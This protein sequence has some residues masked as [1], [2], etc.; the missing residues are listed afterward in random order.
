MNLHLTY[1]DYITHRHPFEN[2]YQGKVVTTLIESR[3]NIYPQAT[4]IVYV[5]GFSDYF[6]QT[7]VM[8]YL[9]GCGVNFYAIDLRKCGRSFMSHQSPNYCQSLREYFAD[10]D[11]AIEFILKKDPYTKIS[12]LGHSTGGL[13]AVYYA[14]FG[15][16]RNNLK[17]LILNAPF[18]D[19]NV[20]FYIKPFIQSLAKKRFNK[21]PYSSMVGVEKMYGES[22][23]KD[24]KGE[25]EYNTDY[26]PIAAFPSY[27]SWILSVLHAQQSSLGE[28][29]LGD[30]PILLLRSDKSGNPKRWTEQTMCSDVVLNVKDMSR[31]ADK[32]SQNVF[33]IV[34]NDALHDVYLSR[35]EVRENALI[36]TAEFINEHL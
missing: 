25:W 12:L 31:L 1:K 13:L 18:L 27:F 7:H 24:Y 26:K 9:N 35:K 3:D 21:D 33:E 32:L 4:T 28:P 20:P 8:H 29:N 23:H 11:Y 14:K 19:F 22:L 10:I 6:F 2:D 30:M 36:K 17:G 16:M 5:H 15:M 34:I